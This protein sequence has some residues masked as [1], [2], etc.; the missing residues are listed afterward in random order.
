MEVLMLLGVMRQEAIELVLR[1]LGKKGL[2]ALKLG[3]LQDT[4]SFWL[5]KL[6]LPMFKSNSVECVSLTITLYM[7]FS[8]S[9]KMTLHKHNWPQWEED[10]I[11]DKYLTAII[12]LMSFI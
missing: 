4:A 9:R 12:I 6:T 7:A 8:A 2:A 3:L 5:Q 11:Q 1:D 10:F